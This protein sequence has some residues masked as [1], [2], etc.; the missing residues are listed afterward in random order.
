M[1]RIWVAGCVLAGFRTLDCHTLVVGFR[2]PEPVVHALGYFHA[3]VVGFRTLV[4]GSHALVVGSRT[5]VAH[6]GV[7]VAWLVA[8]AVGVAKVETAAWLGSCYHRGASSMRP[9]G[10]RC[11]R[12]AQH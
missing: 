6:T 7:L 4:V 1:S 3:L 11:S 12:S 10:C 2:M 8:V 9:L 5:P